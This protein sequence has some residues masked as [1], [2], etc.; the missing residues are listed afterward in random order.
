MWGSFLLQADLFKGGFLFEGKA[1]E[2]ARVG[3]IWHMQAML[4]LMLDTCPRDAPRRVSLLHT[5]CSSSVSLGRNVLF[6]EHLL[7]HHPEMPPGRSQTPP[8]EGPHFFLDEALPSPS[9]G[10]LAL[11]PACSGLCT[12]LEM[13]AARRRDQCTTDTRLHV[14][15]EKAQEEA[16]GRLLCPCPSQRGTWENTL[17]SALGLGHWAKSSAPK[18]ASSR[19]FLCRMDEFSIKPAF[20]AHQSIDEEK[21]GSLP[22]QGWFWTAFSMKQSAGHKESKQAAAATGSEKP[23]HHTC[24]VFFFSERE[25]HSLSPD[26]SM[27]QSGLMILFTAWESSLK[28]NLAAAGKADRKKWLGEI[29]LVL[30]C[31]L[32]PSSST[33]QCWRLRRHSSAPENWVRAGSQEQTSS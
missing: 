31:L 5:A 8:G 25:D 33:H 19:L 7:S 4:C 13:L 2:V 26:S 30:S 15:L 21:Q 14:Q 27:R 6:T 18:Q 23:S 1:E 22:S 24:D 12:C 3:F 29:C 16:T 20:P 28:G 11:L 9:L 17:W 10:L 32:Q